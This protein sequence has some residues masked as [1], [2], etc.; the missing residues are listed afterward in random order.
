MNTPTA[1]GEHRSPLALEEILDRNRTLGR[2][3]DAQGAPR[4]LTP[5][6]FLQVSIEM[7]ATQNTPAYRAL[8]E[9]LATWICALHPARSTL[10]IGCGPGYLLHCLNRLGID[11]LGV[12][13]NP[14]SRA[15]FV[16]RHPE[17]ADRYRLDPLFERAC[18]PA[19]VLI[20]I[21]CF[22]HIPDAGL[23]VLM[24]RVRDEVRPRFIVF[25]STPY[26]DPHPGWDLQWGHINV[27]PPE[28]W[29][30]LF[31]RFGYRLTPHKPPVTEWASL[32][33]EA[34]SEAE[35]DDVR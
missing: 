10:E 24:R 17:H 21:E 33:V 32:Y 3:F 18:A 1:L 4:P 15:F 11:A 5:E 34:A 27:K 13:G 2:G 22:E 6:E 20:A 12:D 30:A 23:E 16:E 31:A 9:S 8:F 7:G 28:A 35:A 26:A 29:H 19:D 25:S 14:H